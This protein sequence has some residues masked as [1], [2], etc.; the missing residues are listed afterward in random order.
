MCHVRSAARAPQWFVRPETPPAMVVRLTAPLPGRPYQVREGTSAACNAAEMSTCDSAFL[1]GGLDRPPARIITGCAPS[2]RRQV[3]RARA[4]SPSPRLAILHALCRSGCAG[5]TFDPIGAV[6]HRTGGPPVRTRSSRQLVPRAFQ[7]RAPDQRGLGPELHDDG[8]RDAGPPRRP[9]AAVR[10]RDLGSRVEQRRHARDLRG[11][12]ASRP[13]G[14]PNSSRPGPGPRGASSRSTSGPIVTVRRH[15]RHPGS[16]PSTASRTRRSSSGRTAIV[17]ASRSSPASF[18]RSRRRKPTRRSSP[19]PSPLRYLE[20][21]ATSARHAD[22]SRRHRGVSRG[23]LNAPHLTN[24]SL[25]RPRR[26][27]S[28]PAAPAV[29]DPDR[30]RAVPD[31][32]QPSEAEAA[33]QRADRLADGPAAAAAAFRQGSLTRG[34]PSARLRTRRVLVL[35]SRP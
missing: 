32:P 15:G 31:R 27:P 10:R 1:A 9:R 24:V 14:S 25:D 19:T 5:A 23:R 11:R 29:A 28:I 34:S 17:S 6:L 7:G 18:A 13:P 22:T 16:T 3:P 30:D 35:E 8:P 26:L 12:R 33:R 2:N 20:L 21:S 4:R